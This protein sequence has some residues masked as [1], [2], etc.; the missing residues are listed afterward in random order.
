MIKIATSSALETHQKKS[1]EVIIPVLEHGMLTFGT[2]RDSVSEI[3]IKH[4]N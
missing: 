2:N 4:P 1:S 3:M